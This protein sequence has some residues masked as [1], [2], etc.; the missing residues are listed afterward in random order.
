M[1]TTF[2]PKLRAS[3]AAPWTE[4][5]NGKI[6]GEILPIG[7]R[8]QFIV[9]ST[10][11]IGDGSISIDMPEEMRALE[12]S[13]YCMLKTSMRNGLLFHGFTI[14]TGNSIQPFFNSAFGVHP[15]TQYVPTVLVAGDELRLVV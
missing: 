9:G 6:L 8:I 10:T 1:I 14:N 13:G 7:I 4:I 15:F 11:V 12:D 5:G 3:Q 2:T